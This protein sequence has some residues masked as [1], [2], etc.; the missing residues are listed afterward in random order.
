MLNRLLDT[1]R[2][3]QE[4]FDLLKSILKNHDYELRIVKIAKNTRV[5]TIHSEKFGRINLIENSKLNYSVFVQSI[6]RKNGSLRSLFPDNARGIRA[7]FG[8]VLKKLLIFKLLINEGFN[9][10]LFLI[11]DVDR[12]FYDIGQIE[13]I[14]MAINELKN[15]SGCSEYWKNSENN[16]QK[17]IEKEELVI[18]IM[19]VMRMS[20]YDSYDLAR[21]LFK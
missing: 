14:K 4:E 12:L 18:E 9:P 6:I 13:D 1:P 5:F 19:N 3:S 11:G 15:H 17:L 8:V 21:K 20:I 2:L 16:Y 7:S 10:D